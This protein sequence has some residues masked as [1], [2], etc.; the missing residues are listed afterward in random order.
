M[1]YRQILFSTRHNASSVDRVRD[2]ISR[3]TYKPST[4]NKED[5]RNNQNIVSMVLVAIV[6]LFFGVLAVIYLGL[7]GKTE[8]LPSLSSGRYSEI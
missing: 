3:S 8:T 2:I 6:A 1:K 5:V 7:G 4:N